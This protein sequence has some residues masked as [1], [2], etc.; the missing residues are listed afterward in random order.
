MIYGRG[1]MD[2]TTPK[3]HLVW[4]LS[5]GRE[6]L[7]DEAIE[8]MVEMYDQGI[9]TTTIG[10]IFNVEGATALR[11]VRYYKK[12]V[13]LEERAVRYCN[14]YGLDELVAVHMAR[15]AASVYRREGVT[16]HIVPRRYIKEST[17]A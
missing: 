12:R 10:S 11:S 6:R 9:D 8:E 5:D 17:H 2:E 7:T 3:G 13:P 15:A 16:F 1:K 4:E 14:H